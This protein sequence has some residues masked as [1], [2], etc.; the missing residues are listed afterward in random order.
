VVALFVVGCAAD[1]K[2]RTAVVLPRKPRSM[3]FQA[4]P[5]SDIYDVAKV[6]A[7]KWSAALGRS[8][9]VTPDGDIPIF[10]VVGD[11]NPPPEGAPENSYVGA[12]AKGIRSPDARIEITERAPN[13]YLLGDLLHEMGHHLRGGPGHVE[14]DPKAVMYYYQPSGTP[15]ELTAADVKFICDGDFDC[16]P[17]AG[18][19]GG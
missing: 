7:D 2:R 11:C 13:E 5:E 17:S 19:T 10:R 12:C 1:A 9:T 3:S 4:D 14:N 15:T 6:A 18:A 16:E 8:I